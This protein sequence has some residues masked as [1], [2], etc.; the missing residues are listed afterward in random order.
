[1]FLQ[2]YI[3]VQGKKKKEIR[4]TGNN[5]QNNYNKKNKLVQWISYE[6]GGVKRASSCTT[7]WWRKNMMRSIRAEEIKRTVLGEQWDRWGEWEAG[8]LAEWMMLCECYGHGYGV[9][10]PGTCSNCAHQHTDRHPHNGIATF[11][12]KLVSTGRP[13]SGDASRPRLITSR[14]HAQP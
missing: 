12:R 5:F 14:A 1:M 8:W 11:Y 2:T 6:H 4:E 10:P 9:G 13:H 3:S 7:V